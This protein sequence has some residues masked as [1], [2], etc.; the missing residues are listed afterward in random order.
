MQ[1]K[2]STKDL[3]CKARFEKSFSFYKFVHGIAVAD[4]DL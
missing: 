1:N 2:A 3:I 4:V